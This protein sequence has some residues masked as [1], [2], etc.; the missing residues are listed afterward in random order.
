VKSARLELRLI[1]AG[2]ASGKKTRR[3]ESSRSF[4]TAVPVDTKRISIVARIP[5][6][7]RSRLNL[8]LLTLHRTMHEP[9]ASLIYSNESNQACG[10]LQSF[11]ASWKF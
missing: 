8:S 11:R 9:L 3:T 5:A 4:Y 6:L 10:I 2:N 7:V 1:G